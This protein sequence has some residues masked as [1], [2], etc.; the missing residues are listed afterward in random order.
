MKVSHTRQD[1]D[2]PQT[3]NYITAIAAKNFKG[4]PETLFDSCVT[5]PPYHLNTQKKILGLI[6]KPDSLYNLVKGFM[7][8][9]WD[10][11]DI[12]F[13]PD[14]WRE[15]FRVLKPGA[16]LLA[17]GGTR[18]YHRMVCAIED[19]GFEIRDQIQWLYGQGFP[20]SF[21]VGKAID[22]AAGVERETIAERAVIL[23]GSNQ[24]GSHSLHL[25]LGDRREV[26]SQY[27]CPSLR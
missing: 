11:G 15:V 5:D 23:G 27:N 25:R 22:N 7:G 24:G 6:P 10:G 2:D 13:R 3:F 21:D 14:V 20:K 12:A 26:A 16:H 17:F 9:E 4:F 18:T 1:S 19:A 8:K